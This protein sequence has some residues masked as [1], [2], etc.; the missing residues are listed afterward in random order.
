MQHPG[1]HAMLA[2]DEA[3]EITLTPGR[4]PSKR[5]AWKEVPD[6]LAKMASPHHRLIT[7]CF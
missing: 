3:H 4:F 2:I 6:N 7:L 1:A 5:S